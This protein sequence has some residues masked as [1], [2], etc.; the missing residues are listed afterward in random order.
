ML[1]ESVTASPCTAEL[2][3]LSL[4]AGCTSRDVRHVE[5]L[6]TR[7]EVDTDHVLC[8]QGEVGEECFVVVR[9]RAAV[10]VDDQLAALIEAGEV[11]GEIA[12]LLASRRRNATVV[13]QTPMTLLVLTRAQ[14]KGL[15]S[16]APSIARNILRETSRRLAQDGERSGHS[17]RQAATAG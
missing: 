17:T 14:L 16:T 5:R 12:L 7:V 9:G 3:Q 15:L 8:R 4:F 1:Y 6:G 11:V 13:A 10:T 2:A